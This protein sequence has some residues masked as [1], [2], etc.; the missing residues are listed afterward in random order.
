MGLGSNVE[1]GGRQEAEAGNQS[2]VSRC[3]ILGNMFP[4]NA[5][6]P[7]TLA[8]YSEQGA[9]IGFPAAAKIMNEEKGNEFKLETF[10][11]LYS[12]LAKVS[13]W[14]SIQF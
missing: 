4:D 2:D 13:G 11:W 12:S 7:N 14:V 10:S 5:I 9:K 6:E 3:L 8:P 1:E